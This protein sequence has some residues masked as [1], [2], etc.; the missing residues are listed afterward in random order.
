[1]REQLFKFIKEAKPT[2]KDSSIKNY[3]TTFLK[4]HTITDDR[5]MRHY[6]YRPKT[7]IKEITKLS[8]SNNTKKN[9]LSA[10]INVMTTYKD[11]GK[12]FT[13]KRRDTAIN[14]Y[15]K[16]IFHLKNKVEKDKEQLQDGLTQRERQN[17]VTYEQVKAGHKFY[18][19]LVNKAQIS[20]H[21]QLTGAEF[22]L[23]QKWVLT[24]LYSKLPP[25]RNIYATLNIKH[26]EAIENLPKDKNYLVFNKEDETEDGI[27]TIY[28]IINQHKSNKTL[29]SRV[30][31]ITPDS[32]FFQKKNEEP[33]KL[34]LGKGLHEVLMRWNALIGHKQS[35]M[36][37]NKK[38]RQMNT[39]S[40]TKYLIQTYKALYPNKRISTNILRKAFHSTRN[41]ISNFKKHYQE[42]KVFAEAMGHSLGE[43]VA[44]YT[45]KM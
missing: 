6:Y 45:K 8:L 19:T 43:A 31:I 12:L 3:I 41:K 18:N 33:Q 39:N 40:M 42:N 22:D 11:Q 14:E 10:I 1:M 9:Y 24:S 28:I 30:W 38:G 37:V 2:L 21:R 7:I 44:S 34:D 29:G 32:T 17:M 15:R 27:T 35:Y 36:F 26:N 25:A 5:Q 16:A 20:N 13:G 4:F 23:I